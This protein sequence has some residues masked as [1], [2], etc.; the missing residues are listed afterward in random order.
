MHLGRRWSGAQYDVGRAG[1]WCSAARCACCPQCPRSRPW[2]NGARC[3]HVVGDLDQV[4]ELDAVFRARCRQRPTIDAGVGADLDVVADAHGAQLFDLD[5]ALG[6]GRKA[7]AVGPMTAPLQ[8]DAN[9]RQSGNQIRAP[10]DASRVPAPICAA[11]TKAAGADLRA[12]TDSGADSIT[13]C[14]PMST[15]SPSTAAAATTAHWGARLR[16]QAHAPSPPLRE[17]CKVAVG[18]RRDDGGAT[19]ARRIAGRR[20]DHAGCRRALASWAWYFGDWRGS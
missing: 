16:L 17:P 7:K 19:R 20:H 6:R 11:P 18:V 15:P 5:V 1:P 13:A 9:A 3:A 12:I 8:D 14:G 2:P 4:V 10:P